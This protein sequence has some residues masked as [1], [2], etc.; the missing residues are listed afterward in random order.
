MM[1]ST[2]DAGI[3]QFLLNL[4]PLVT[5]IR[6]IYDLYMTYIYDLYMTGIT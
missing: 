6:L 4:L 1:T 2:A 3:Q 5:Y